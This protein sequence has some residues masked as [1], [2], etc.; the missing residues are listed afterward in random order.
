MD[1]W[2]ITLSNTQKLILLD[3]LEEESNDE[4][5]GF[6]LP[7]LWVTSLNK[8]LYR[9][10]KPR[11]KA[12]ALLPGGAEHFFHNADSKSLESITRI[13]RRTFD[14]IIPLFRPQWEKSKE[15]HP[16]QKGHI[17]KR[18]I[19]CVATLGFSPFYFP[20]PPFYF[21]SPFSLTPCPLR[22]YF[23][24]VG[25]WHTPERSSIICWFGD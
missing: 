7:L 25:N 21:L 2:T 1:S 23:V 12:S 9:L 13:D 16:K 22:Y 8:W 14:Y 5:N 15:L 18:K 10:D 17:T 6:V 4:T 19:S 24:L 11:L 3:C 20:S